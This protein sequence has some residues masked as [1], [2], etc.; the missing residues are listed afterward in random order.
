MDHPRD[1]SIADPEPDAADVVTVEH[2][3]PADAPVGLVLE[4]P[5]GATEDVHFRSWADR[6]R[7]P[8]PDDL[9]EFFR[10]NT[11]FGAPELAS[12]VARR[13][14]AASRSARVV[15]GLVPRT[16]IDLNRDVDRADGSDGMTP[17]LPPY[18]PDVDDR[19]L[20]T[21]AWLTYQRVAERVH[22]AL[23]RTYGRALALHTYAP[24]SVAVE[25]IDG[26]IVARLRRA[27]E[28]GVV[29][30]WPLR[31]EVDVIEPE[32]DSAVRVDRDLSDAL[33]ACLARTGG[34]VGRSA[35]YRLV[36]TTIAHR[37][38][39]RHPGATACLEVRRDRLGAPWK[40]FE[41][42]ELD[43]D[44]VDRFADAIANAIETVSH[45]PVR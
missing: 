41:P 18:V 14:S 24:R 11:D 19:E 13:Y 40:P 31:P 25:R 16:L 32:Q 21:G 8:L 33:A 28:A 34:D 43:R 26:D 45:L 6:L 3:G 7:G 42:S 38:A 36:P 44:G 15:R 2:H 5:H 9:I 1:R 12:A 37:R 17:G 30:T 35:T 39:A 27:Y 22:D 4:V 20:L 23:D 29:E 10:V